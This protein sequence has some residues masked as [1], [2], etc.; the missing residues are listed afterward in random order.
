VREGFDLLYQGRIQRLIISGVHPQATLYDLLRE[1]PYY[2]KINE[3]D[4][5]LEKRSQ[6]TYGNAQQSLPLA[7]ALQCRDI[8]LV[9]SA[10]HMTRAY[11]TFRKIFPSEITLHS[12]SIVYGRYRASLEDAMVEAAKLFF[13]SLW[14]F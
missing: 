6:T 11:K 5:V 2:G 4:V 7:E 8:L 13:Y 3:A 1:W 9:T 10:L 14:V 12:H